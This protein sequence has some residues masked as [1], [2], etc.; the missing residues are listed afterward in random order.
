M[1]A[2]LESASLVALLYMQ[3]ANILIVDDLNFPELQKCQKEVVR[4]KS[5]SDIFEHETDKLNT[6]IGDLERELAY[7][8]PTYANPAGHS[9]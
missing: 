1:E 8:N 4:A 9:N 7:A 3:K 5:W 6:R 2:A